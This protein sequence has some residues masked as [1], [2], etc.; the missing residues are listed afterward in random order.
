[1]VESKEAVD[2]LLSDLGLGVPDWFRGTAAR[3]ISQ[4]GGPVRGGLMEA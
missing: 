2:E 3:S 4:Y 1:M